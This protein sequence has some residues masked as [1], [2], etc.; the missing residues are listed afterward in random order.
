M[1]RTLCVVLALGAV[2]SCRNGSTDTGRPAGPTRLTNSKP[3][4]P[5]PEVRAREI[6]SAQIAAGAIEQ[7]AARDDAFHATFTDDAVVLG[8]SG[9]TPAA[10]LSGNVFEHVRITTLV[11]DGNAEAGL[12]RR[13]DPGHRVSRV[14]KSRLVGIVASGPVRR[15]GRSVQGMESRRRIARLRLRRGSW[16]RKTGT[17]SDPARHSHVS[18]DELGPE[19]ARTCSRRDGVDDRRRCRRECDRPRAPCARSVGESYSGP[20]SGQPGGAGVELGRGASERGVSRGQRWRLRGRDPV[21]GWNLDAGSRSIPRA[22]G[23]TLGRWVWVLR[24]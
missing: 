6:I 7:E 10:E 22:L 1:R 17:G 9:A 13:R 24:V 3:L 18:T 5:A 21:L 15:C 4:G 8:M 11:A 12:V 14:T 23:V 2:A 19:R 20:R 16:I